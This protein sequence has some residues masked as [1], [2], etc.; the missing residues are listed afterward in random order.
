M[1]SKIINNTSPKIVSGQP[2]NTKKLGDII[3]SYVDSIN[4]GAVPNFI[5][6]WDQIGEDAALEAYDAGI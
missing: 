6:A 2:L 5:S 1:R 4:K 3:I